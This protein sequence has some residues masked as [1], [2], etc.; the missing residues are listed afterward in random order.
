MQAMDVLVHTSVREGIPR[1]VPQAHVV[2]KPVVAF[3]LDGTPEVVEHGRSGFLTGVDPTEVAE[4]VLE[5]LAD[6]VRAARMGEAGRMFASENFSVERMVRRINE[7]Y[8]ELLRAQG[9]L[10]RA[11]FVAQPW[12]QSPLR[13]SAE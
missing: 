9:E 5:V 3:A 13:A 11:P 4:R 12:G 1:V 8:R 10:A 6:P 2:G 7:V